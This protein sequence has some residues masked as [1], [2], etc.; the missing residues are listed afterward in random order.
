MRG[1]GS[2]NHAPVHPEILQ[3]ITHENIEHAPS[4]GTDKSSFECLKLFKDHFGQQTESH[5][6]FNGTAANVLSLRTIMKPFE[7]CFVTDC[8][9]LNLDECAAPEFFAGKLIPIPSHHGKF[10]FEDLEKHYIR[11]GDQHFAQP[12][13]ISI[14]QPT[15]LG[16]VYT[17]DELKKIINWAKEK[18][19]IVHMDGARFSN[20]VSFLN[21]KM[22][23]ITTDLGVDILSFG[24]T[25]NGLM[26]GE[27]V[28]IINPLFQK[29]FK[30]IRKQAAQLPSKTRFIACQF[31]RYF[32]DELY[33]KIAKSSHDLACYLAEQILLHCP[34]IQISQ[35]TE[36]NAVFCK[37]PKEWIKPLRKNYF[38]YVWNENT[39]ECRLMM[40]WDNQKSDIDGFIN[41]VKILEQK[42]HAPKP[43]PF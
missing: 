33:L 22:K 38:F 1:F 35:P 20:A 7:S 41:S 28:V 32:K 5:F 40:S 16:T 39:F 43:S 19:M 13:V 21:C 11:L 26:F 9:H 25:K 24:G 3:A 29:D 42:Q 17:V 10:I 2:D 23:S 34:D 37:I 14:T 31:Q 4:Y 15:E 8:S 27:A 18:N 12:K 36:S 6:V 30:F